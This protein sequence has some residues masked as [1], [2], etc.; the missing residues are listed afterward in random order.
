MISAFH[1]LFEVFLFHV[2]IFFSCF[3]FFFLELLLGVLLFVVFMN[4]CLRLLA[5]LKRLQKQSK[6][7]L[8]RQRDK[9]EDL[10]KRKFL[11]LLKKKEKRYVPPGMRNAS[12]GATSAA[13]A[14][15]N[16]LRGGDGTAVVGRVQPGS[17]SGASVKTSPAASSAAAAAA[18]RP[19]RQLIV[20]EVPDD[21]DEKERDK[22][23]KKAA[24]KA[25]K[26][27]AAHAAKEAEEAKASGR[28]NFAADAYSTDPIAVEKRIKKLKTKLRQIDQLKTKDRATLTVEQRAKLDEEAS[29]VR[30]VA[31]LESMRPK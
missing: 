28:Q 15:L 24:K 1:S 19:A 20:G 9:S 2:L 25:A 18:V 5:A 21:E 13:T 16:S 14:S 30:L 26:K 8:Q 17:A 27:E 7:W 4:L 23:R 31:E 6:R 29:V 3:F 11:C 12:P 10:K 22:E